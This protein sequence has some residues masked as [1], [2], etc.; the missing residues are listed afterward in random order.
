MADIALHIREPL[1]RITLE[2]MLR[3]EGHTIVAEGGAVGIHDHPQR[4]VEEA[5]IRPSLLL[6]GAADIPAA[7]DAM[8]QGVYGYIFLPFQPGETSLMVERALREVQVR[9]GIPS[10]LSVPME[11]ALIDAERTHIERVLR[12]CRGNRTVAA[13]RLGIGRN[14]LWR[15][16]RRYGTTG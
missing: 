14:T 5:C 11:T 10:E 13:K 4:A 9:A 15:R 7:V 6:A 1:N 12:E 8:R 2:M 3:A 16:L